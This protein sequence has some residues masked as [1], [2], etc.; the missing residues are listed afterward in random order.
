MQELTG[1]QTGN[2]YRNHFFDYPRNHSAS[3]ICRSD[4]SM[5]T[6]PQRCC[7]GVQ[8]HYRTDESRV[9][10]NYRYGYSTITSYQVFF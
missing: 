9:P 1:P 10:A 7:P 3:R 8:S 5:W 4:I 2:I 6:A